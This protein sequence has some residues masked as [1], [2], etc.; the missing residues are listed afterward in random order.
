ML[1]NKNSQE[2]RAAAAKATAAYQS[3]LAR[4]A[5]IAARMAEIE[6]EKEIAAFEAQLAAAGRC[7][8]DD[9]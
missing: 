2:E 3:K 9:G 8:R 7:C 1:S 5:E 6:I 4:D